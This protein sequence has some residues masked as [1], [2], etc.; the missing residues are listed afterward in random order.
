MSARRLK[1][2]HLVALAGVLTAVLGGAAAFITPPGGPGSESPS[3]FSA[4]AGGG[5]A[6]FLTLKAL[7]Y[8]IDRSYEPMTAIAATPS[9]TMLLMTGTLR[10]SDLDRRA[11]EA[12]LEAG[13]SVL[14]VGVQG[15]DFLS[16]AGAAPFSSVAQPVRHRAVTPS[17]LAVRASEITMVPVSGAPKF[18]SPYV[19]VFSGGDDNPLVATARVGKGRVIWLAAPTPLTNAHIADAGNL[20]L[21]LNAAGDPGE[22][23]LLWDEH[24]HGHSRSLWSYAA[25]TPLPW[26]GAQLA[27]L[28]TFAL[29]T[30]SRRRGP[31]R[32]RRTDART[33]PLEFI[34][35]LGALYRR[36][37]AA[38]AAVA[39]ARAR[40]KRT[41][42]ATQGIP[43]DSPDDAVAKAIATRSGA[44]VGEVLDVL[45]AADRAV[46]DARLNAADALELTRRL[47][48]LTAGVTSSA[49]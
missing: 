32:A 48:Q 3:S 15:A 28:L 30:Y 17:P 1:D 35:M 16:V 8:R 34:D 33:S 11:L 23:T 10:P 12:F 37:G 27:V 40:L 42:G 31:V 39:A 25:R 36:A 24:Y 41:V 19:T 26:I 4:A 14:L 20:Q 22:A 18:A 29:A 38:P 21:L 47:Q 7:G 13:G 5:K 46:R 6:A 44:D 9:D 45:S 2:V 49:S 43:A